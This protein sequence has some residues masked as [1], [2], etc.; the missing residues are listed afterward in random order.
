M[1]IIVVEY[2][3]VEKIHQVRNHSFSAFLLEKVDKVIVC[4]RH[5]LDENLADDAD[6]RLAKCAVDREMVKTLYDFTAEGRIAL[7]ALPCE[8]GNTT[9]AKLSMQRVGGT[10]D[11]FIGTDP[12]ETAEKEIAENNGPAGR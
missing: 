4:E 10:G 1:F 3:V 2:T 5:V 8:T 9:A 7:P 12:I 6:A 11:E